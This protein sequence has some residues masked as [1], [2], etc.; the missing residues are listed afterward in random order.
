MLQELFEENKLGDI[1]GLHNR[2]SEN[3]INRIIEIVSKWLNG[4]LRSKKI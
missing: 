1:Y 3:P 2:S 4:K